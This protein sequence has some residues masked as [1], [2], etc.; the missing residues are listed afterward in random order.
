MSEFRSLK[1]SSP[2]A[3][4]RGAEGGLLPAFETEEQLDEHLSRP[5]PEL[6]ED[7]ARVEGDLLVLGVAGKMG[8]SLARMAR[9]AW[10]AAGQTRRRVI[11]VARFSEPGS[12]DA[13]ERH[14]VETIACDLMDE[15][16]WQALPEAANVIYMAARKFGSAGN[17]PLTWAVNTYLPGRIAERFR[18]SRIV[19]FSTGNVY[20]FVPVGSGGPTEDH[21]VGPVGEYAQS[22][23]GRERMFQHFSAVYGTPG[24]ILRLNYAV[25]PRYGVLLDIA[26]KVARG[27]PIDVTMGY[28]NVIW[29]GDANA[30]ALRSLTVCA[31]P[32]LILNLTG[33]ETLSV[34][35]VAERF[36]QLMGRPAPAIVGTEAPTVL[37]NDASRCH[38]RFGLPRVSAEQVLRWVAHWVARGG[39]EL[40]KPTKFQVR[41]GRF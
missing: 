17:E 36:A 4:V 5:S 34:R 21:P 19:S 37:L 39:R 41:D 15:R 1:P 26:R 13:L 30:V 6:I 10:H 35:Q 9:R 25:E 29:Q 38:K 24:A 40:N 8:P 28:V 33:P 32:P 2:L 23:L 11:G 18:K 16:Q 22:C 27:D 20:P 7:L 31:S 12:K 14:G 3:E